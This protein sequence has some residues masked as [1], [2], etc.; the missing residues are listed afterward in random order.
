MSASE[1]VRKKLGKEI[2]L[3]VI[4]E[5]AYRIFR[6]ELAKH[7]HSFD[8]FLERAKQGKVPEARKFSSV[9]HTIK[10]G[11]GFFGLTEIYEISGR[12]E[13]L[14]EKDDLAI[15]SSLDQVRSLFAKLKDASQE[16]IKDK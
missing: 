1:S 16:L 5:K 12:L 6:D 7:L 8:A 4:C 9:F 14:L 2:Q 3:R 13:D 11:A 10:G 15:S